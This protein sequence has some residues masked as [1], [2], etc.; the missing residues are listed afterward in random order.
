MRPPPFDSVDL[1][2]L[3]LSDIPAAA[4]SLM[5][6]DGERTHA[7]RYVV[8]NERLRFV[9]GRALLRLV[10]ATYLET[11][12]PLVPL[13]PG[14]NRKPAL[15]GSGLIFSLSRAGDHFLCVVASSRAVGIDVEPLSILPNLD[16]LLFVCTRR[17][18][19]WIL[20]GID[21]IERSMRFLRIWTRKEAVLKALGNR[22]PS[23]DE[24]DVCD[25]NTRVSE[26]SFAFA[27]PEIS[28]AFCS[29][30]CAGSQSP[31]VRAKGPASL[32]TFFPPAVASLV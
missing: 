14:A 2:Q 1:W 24:I 19:I 30:A 15:L 18:R 9:R 17:E 12:P 23:P 13:V 11:E 6:S 7:G 28:G 31:T 26:Q 27:D 32:G 22:G 16:E 10:L 4:A 5:L 21:P 8:L 25:I 20:A 3:E 29:L